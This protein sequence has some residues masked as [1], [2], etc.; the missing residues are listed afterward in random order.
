[1]GKFLFVDYVISNKLGKLG[2]LFLTVETCRHDN[3]C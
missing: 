1:M 3:L 2:M